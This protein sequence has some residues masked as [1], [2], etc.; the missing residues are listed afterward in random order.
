MLSLFMIRRNGDALPDLD[1]PKV[2]KPFKFRFCRTPGS[3]W[4]PWWDNNSLS[5]LNNR[6]GWQPGVGPSIVVMDQGMAR[7]FTTATQ[8]QGVHAFMFDQQGLMAGM[9]CKAPRSRLTRWTTECSAIS[10]VSGKPTFAATDG[11]PAQFIF[12]ACTPGKQATPHAVV[13]QIVVH[14][15]S[16][17]CGNT[18]G[19]RLRWNAEL[20]CPHIGPMSGY[21]TYETCG[22]GEIWSAFEVN[23]DTGPPFAEVRV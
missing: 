16:S 7:S 14:S 5:F 20:Q 21:G 18:D 3:P 15:G 23:P 2:Y 9:G 17:N 6:G 12:G 10:R 22:L 13:G 11:A 1:A 19:S 8:L 4:P